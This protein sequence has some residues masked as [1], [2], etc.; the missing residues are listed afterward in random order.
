MGN[1]RPPTAIAGYTSR[2]PIAKALAQAYPE[3]YTLSGNFF[4][5]RTVPCPVFAKT[6]E[7]LR[8]TKGEPPYSEEWIA[9]AIA[10]ALLTSPY[11]ASKRLGLKDERITGWLKGVYGY[12]K[13][14]DK[15]LALA[16]EYAQQMKFKFENIL[17]LAL[18]AMPDKM[19]NASLGSLG[20]V[21]DLAFNKLQLIDGKPTVIEGTSSKRDMQAAERAAAIYR[22]IADAKARQDAL[23]VDAID[24]TPAKD[25][26]GA[27]DAEFTTES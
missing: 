16:H 9:Q 12:K 10:L 21:A 1:K 22:L 5:H 20:Y 23:E 3:E 2:Q 7:E 19:A 18:D 17:D 14:S 24:I 13:V 27:I 26:S 4:C 25:N 15:T 6:F 11:K 8:A